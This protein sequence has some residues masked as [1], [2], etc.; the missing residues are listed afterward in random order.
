MKFE[1]S[2]HD[3]V[4]RVTPSGALVRVG[5]RVFGVGVVSRWRLWLGLVSWR[6]GRGWTVGGSYVRCLAREGSS[7]GGF[8]ASE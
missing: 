6:R 3:V 1:R 8:G 5:H 4:W 7:C 2:L